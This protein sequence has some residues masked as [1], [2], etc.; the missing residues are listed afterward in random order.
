MTNT[1]LAK[2]VLQTDAHMESA[3]IMPV[4]SQ[5]GT[6]KCLSNNINFFQ[7]HM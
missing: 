3:F 7:S 2:R 5:K 6:L 4:I 1:A